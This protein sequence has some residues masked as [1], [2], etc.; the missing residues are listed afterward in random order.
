MTTQE[1]YRK[2]IL[3]GA[4]IET[5]YADAM[6]DA[7]FRTLYPHLADATVEELQAIHEQFAEEQRKFDQ[8]AHLLYSW[9][10]EEDYRLYRILSRTTA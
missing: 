7:D 10:D 5:E 6:F 9:M 2:R 4:T 3:Q 8:A 1:M